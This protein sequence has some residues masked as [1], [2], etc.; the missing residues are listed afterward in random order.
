MLQ[1]SADIINATLSQA[2][3]SEKGKQIIL[4]DL[5]PAIYQSL[6]KQAHYHRQKERPDHTL[7]TTALVHEAFLKL[8]KSDIP[9][10]SPKQVMMLSSRVI[11]NIL[12]DYARRRNASKR[13]LPDGEP[14]EL[15]LDKN[16]KV[17]VLDLDRALHHLSHQ[18]RQL[19]KLVECRFYGGMTVSETAEALDMSK[20]SVER[21]W[22]RAKA[23]LYEYLSE[24]YG[25]H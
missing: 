10:D 25:H 17:G 18:S 15:W 21:S 12:V 6:R 16:M 4:D 24:D 3:V 8:A 5:I 9:C 14:T 19:E 11:R 1:S 23:Y 20:R 22:S 13:Q 2:G 7:Q